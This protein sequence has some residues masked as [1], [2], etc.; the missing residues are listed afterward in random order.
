ETEIE[1]IFVTTSMHPG[2]PS[3]NYAMGSPPRSPGRRGV[4]S[5]EQDGQIDHS[6]VPSEAGGPGGPPSY[7]GSGGAGGPGQLY[8][9]RGHMEGQRVRMSGEW[10][11]SKLHGAPSHATYVGPGVV[12]GGSSGQAGHHGHSRVAAAAAAYR[13]GGGNPPH[14]V[15][16]PSDRHHPRHPAEL[17]HEQ[18]QQQQQRQFY[19]EHRPARVDRHHSEPILGHGDEGLR[20]MEDIPPHL[21]ELSSHRSED[22]HQRPPHAPP[23][24]GASLGAGREGDKAEASLEGAGPP[25]PNSGK[26]E[27]GTVGGDSDAVKDFSQFPS[28]PEHMGLKAHAAEFVPFGK[29]NSK[30]G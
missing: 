16:R 4:R 2:Y 5:Y 17:Q 28:S 25:S 18:Q 15:M 19:D 22:Q 6:W 27:R 11:P 29:D 10:V 26:E 7:R 14:M 30:G 24:R 21:H 13:M 8:S 1:V 3:Y 23:P 12:H 9:E 20:I